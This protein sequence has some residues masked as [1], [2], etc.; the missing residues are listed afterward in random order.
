MVEEK[1]PPIDLNDPDRQLQVFRALANP[2][3]LAILRFLHNGPCCATLPCVKLGISQ[4]NLSRHLQVLKEAGLID[5]RLQGTQHCY[6]IC[7][8]SLLRPV[9]A[10]LEEQHP[11]RPCR[12]PE[13]H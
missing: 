7:R 5:Y 1:N 10:L 6:F 13:Q 8:P 9:F 4:P 3:R 11:Y 2:T 12:K